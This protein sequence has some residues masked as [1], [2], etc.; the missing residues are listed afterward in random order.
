MIA[1]N[2]MLMHLQRK[3]II[4]LFVM[5]I[6]RQIRHGCLR[7]TLALLCHNSF[8]DFRGQSGDTR[9]LPSI[10]HIAKNL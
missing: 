1:L 9:K 8:P 10:F 3:L 7:S 5:S 4:I 2:T 6:I